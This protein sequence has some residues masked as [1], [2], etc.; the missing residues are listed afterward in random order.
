MESGRWGEPEG[1]PNGSPMDSPQTTLSEA[2][3]QEATRSARVLLRLAPADAQALESFAAA[4]GLARG[5]A[6]RALLRSALRLATT[7][8][9]EVA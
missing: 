6:A 7:T 9:A 2:I 8:T 5:E 3:A 1:V 4:S